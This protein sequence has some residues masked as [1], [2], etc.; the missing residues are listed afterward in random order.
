MTNG[1][2]VPAKEEE[3]IDAE[4]QT[5]KKGGNR[6]TTILLG[7]CVILGFFA[8]LAFVIIL[9]AAA[10]EL[11]EDTEIGGAIIDRI[12]ERIEGEK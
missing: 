5:L 12:V 2:I 8:I 7:A 11:I 3:R 1:D 4:K 6:V 9:F 10:V